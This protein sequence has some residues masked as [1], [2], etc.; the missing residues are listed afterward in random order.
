[1]AG[2]HRKRASHAAGAS[3]TRSR[4]LGTPGRHRANRGNL[5]Y[6]DRVAATLARARG[7]WG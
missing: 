2:K 6:G 4:T 5:S 7:R 3:A 1:M